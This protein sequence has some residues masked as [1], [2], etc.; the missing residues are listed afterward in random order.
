MKLPSVAFVTNDQVLHEGLSSVNS[1]EFITWI[2]SDCENLYK[3]LLGRAV[4]VLGAVA[5][6]HG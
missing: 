5:V 4:D 1:A 3:N 2:V 6:L